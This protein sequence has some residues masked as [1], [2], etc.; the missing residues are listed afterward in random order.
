MTSSHDVK[1]LPLDEYRYQSM[2]EHLTQLANTK[3]WHEYAMQKAEQYAKWDRVLYAKL[4][5]DLWQQ[6]KEKSNEIV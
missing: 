1:F 5:G 4:P 2:L 3:G 6:L